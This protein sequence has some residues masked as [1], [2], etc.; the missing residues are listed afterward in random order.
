MAAAKLL[1]QM[2]QTRQH[3]AMVV[4]EFGGVDGLVTMEDLVE[5]VVGDIEDEHDAP[6]APTLITRA[7]GTLLVDARLSIE[8]FGNKTGFNLP[9]LEGEDI[10]TL[11][12]YVANLAGHVPRIGEKVA[13]SGFNFEVLEMDQGRIRRLRIRPAHKPE[14]NIAPETRA[15]AI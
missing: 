11:G 10:D 13:G 4:D 14:I 9:P 2:R 3:M 15:G 12:G 8:D 6:P 5:E 7:D 1:L